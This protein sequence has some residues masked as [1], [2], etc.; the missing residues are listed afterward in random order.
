MDD[1]NP[2]HL[3][4]P[5]NRG[6][7][8]GSRWFQFS[9]TSLFV[10][11]TVSALILSTYFSVG[12]LLGMSNMEVLTQGLRRS[13]FNMPVVLVWIIGLGM[14]I[15]RLKRNR[16]AATLTMIA[17]GG[18][19]LTSLC[20]QVACMALIHSLNSGRINFELYRWVSMILEVLDTIL[21]TACWIVILLA[22]FAR[23]PPDAPQPERADP[24]G[25]PPG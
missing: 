11:V 20:L 19:L 9:L 18:L 10:L 14:A 2:R 5:S 8:R 16:A 4:P 23:R 1:G 22:I 25:D 13:L 7:A 17:L 3:E 15:R 21:D 6:A 12:R 24:G